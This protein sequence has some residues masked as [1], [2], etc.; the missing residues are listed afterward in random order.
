[1]ELGT[2]KR[3]CLE[4][5]ERNSRSIELDIFLNFV[6]LLGPFIPS[7]VMS[8]RFVV[9]AGIKGKLLEQI[10]CGLNRQMLI[11]CAAYFDSTVRLMLHIKPLL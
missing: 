2:Q 6:V 1:M 9:H 11:D 7:S 8:E 4:Q 10:A 5:I 3:P